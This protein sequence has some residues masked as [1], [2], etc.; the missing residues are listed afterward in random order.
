MTINTLAP[1]EKDLFKIVS[2]IRELCQGRS[3]ANGTV[4]LTANAGSTVVPAVTCATGA[5]PV[6]TPLSPHASADFASGAFYVSAI[7][8][9]AFTITHPNNANSDKTFS[10]AVFG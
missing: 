2:V 9:G 1:G 5:T 10:W 7:S 3:N 6:L 4:T 8:N